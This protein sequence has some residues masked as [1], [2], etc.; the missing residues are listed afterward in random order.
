MKRIASSLSLALLSGCAWLH[1]VD[2]E[3]PAPVIVPEAFSGGTATS[4]VAEGRWW[5]AFDD[6]ALDELQ[7]KAFAHNLD[8]RRAFLRLERAM[9]V[10]DA[11]DAAWWPTL[12]ASGSISQSQR[13]FPVAR[14]PDGSAQFGVVTQNSGALQLAAGY[15]LDVFGRVKSQTSAAGFELLA[16]RYDVDAIAMSISAQ[17]AEAWYQLVEQRA[18]LA[19]IDAQIAANATYLEL[20]ELRFAEGLATA[21]DVLQQRQQVAGSNAQRPLVEARIAVLEHQLAVLLGAPPE[22]LES[23]ARAAFPALPALPGVGVPA[24]LVRRRPDVRAAEA[25]VVAADYRVGA[26]IAARFPAL[27]LEGSYGLQI[28][29]IAGFF[30]NIVRSLTASLLAP[31]WDG[32]RRAAEVDNAR[33]VLEDAVTA[34]G[35]TVLVAFQEVEDAL[36]REK[37][38]RE[39]LVEV[40]KQVEAAQ[41]TLDEA[42]NR[43]LAGLDPYLPVLTA[44]RQFQQVEQQRL[45]A[46][47][48]L[49]SFRIQLCRSLGGSWMRDLERPELLSAAEDPRAQP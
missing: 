30:D 11:A 12:D 15:E 47:R 28:L 41:R 9:A 39:H 24:D 44:L 32:G 3:R 23:P 20:T 35:Q 8:L 21:L 33:A 14:N 4:S 13:L 40:D 42:L 31:I 18:A 2:H 17:V 46:Q 49:L 45:A 48:Q 10:S 25:R 19:L 37:K 34:Y 22:H 29:S 26:A 1:P 16:S 38:Q 5:T 43:Y 6:D 27:R 7:S 36:A